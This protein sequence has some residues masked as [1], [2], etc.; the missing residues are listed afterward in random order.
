M[1]SHS[2]SDGTKGTKA[3]N[4]AGAS[5]LRKRLAL[6]GGG[7]IG[8]PRPDLLFTAK[9]RAPSLACHPGVTAN[10]TLVSMVCVR[11]GEAEIVL[12]EFGIN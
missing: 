6:A 8:E 2:D 3:T 7:D 1:N 12:H 10:D 4:A 5:A 11:K 9:G